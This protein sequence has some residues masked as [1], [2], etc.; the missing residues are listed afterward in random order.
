MQRGLQSVEAQNDRIDL[1]HGF[2][3]AFSLLKV[4]AVRSVFIRVICGREFSRLFLLFPQGIL[5]LHSFCTT[6]S[7][8][9]V[10]GI[11]HVKQSAHSAC[12]RCL[13][14]LLKIA[15]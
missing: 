14:S 15:E 6:E 7:A 8:F 2:G 5:I 4:E 12:V 13:K 9:S 11:S 1:G 3:R 10:A